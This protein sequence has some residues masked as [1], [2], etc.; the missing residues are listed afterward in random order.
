MGNS[1][2]WEEAKEVLSFLLLASGIA[3]L[4]FYVF[5]VL[6]PTEKVRDIIKILRK[7]GAKFLDLW[8]K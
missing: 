8:R 1:L 4:V 2:E 5:Y 6:A 7:I 3:A